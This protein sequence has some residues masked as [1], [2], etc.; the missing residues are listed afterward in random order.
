MYKYVKYRNTKKFYLANNKETEAKGHAYMIT[1]CKLSNN[2][3]EVVKAPST[4]K[5][6]HL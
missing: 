3:Y 1:E 6:L 5:R 2:D 4:R